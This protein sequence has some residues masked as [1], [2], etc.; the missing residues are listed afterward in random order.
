M[1]PGSF[2][3]GVPQIPP[4]D[5]LFPQRLA[6][7]ERTRNMSHIVFGTLLLVLAGLFAV[8]QH[9]YSRHHRWRRLLGSLDA[10]P[11]QERALRDLVHSARDQLQQ[12]HLDGRALRREIGEVVRA[13]NFDEGQF[14]GTEARIGEKIRE[15]ASVIRGTLLQMHEILDARQRAKLADWLTSGHHCY[16]YSHF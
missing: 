13:D 1:N 7:P 15:A 5:A 2:F 10:S 3:T 8:R 11:A 4:V 14:T 6:R 16:R 9:R 12:I